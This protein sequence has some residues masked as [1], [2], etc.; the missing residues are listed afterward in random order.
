M[1]QGSDP[2]NDLHDTSQ[3][4]AEEQ[5]NE[6]EAL[7]DEQEELK[8]ETSEQAESADAE[9]NDAAENAQQEEESPNAPEEDAEA[10]EA[11]QAE[12]H[13]T[14]ELQ[15]QME[16][17]EQRNNELEQRI[18][19]LQADFDNYRK[20]TR[21]EKEE[22]QKFAALN[23]I[24]QLLPIA[25]NFER[26]LASSKQTKDFDGLSKGIEMI[27]AQLFQLMEKEGIEEIQSVGEPFNPEFHQAVM[28]VESE[29]HE[30]GIVVEELQKGYLYHGRVIRPAMVKVS[31]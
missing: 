15:R 29:E 4:Q 20:R 7:T 31:K 22:L 19:R 6:N 11:K 12:D 8:Q 28:Q 23:F 13:E 10:S 2:I 21:N 5:K 27:Y 14:D 17:L 16:Q 25:D 24:E 9:T 1:H 18:L 26:A 3:A 30:E